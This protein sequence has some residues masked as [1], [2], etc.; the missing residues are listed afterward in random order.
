MSTI[1]MSPISQGI[2]AAVCTVVIASQSI[3]G[4]PQWLRIVLGLGAAACGWLVPSPIE[5]KA[6]TP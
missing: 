5:A 3:E 1:Q 4:L 2:V 6:T